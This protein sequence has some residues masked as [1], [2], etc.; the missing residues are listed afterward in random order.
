MSKETKELI[1]KAFDDLSLDYE[2]HIDELVAEPLGE[3]DKNVPFR[4]QPIRGKDGSLIKK[5]VINTNYDFMGS[6]ENMQERIMKNYN[7]K[8]L[9][10]NSIE[11]LI[12]HEVAHILTFQDIDTYVGYLIAN[13]QI[14]KRHIYGISNYADVSLDGAECIAEAFSAIRCGNPISNEAQKLVNEFIERWRK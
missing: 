5:I 4:F 6:Q 11:G 13:K 8:T 1:S 10:A 14:S 12:A 9:T 2:I 7:K 3:A